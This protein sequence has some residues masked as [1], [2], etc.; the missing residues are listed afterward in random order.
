M[1]EYKNELE[2]IKGIL[3]ENPRGMTISE[4]A[5]KLNINRNAVAKYLDV[6]VISGQL[7]MESIGTAKVYYLSQR[8]P[9]STMLNF[10]SDYILVFDRSLKVIQVNDNFLDLSGLKKEDVIGLDVADS[11]LLVTSN[12]LIVSKMKAVVKGEEYKGE[13][14]IPIAQNL[15]YFKIKLIPSTFEDGNRGVTL[16]M[17][18]IT[19]EKE[20]EE[21]LKKHR[22]HL[23]EL[24][25][26]RTKEL[27][28][29]N[30]KLEEE[31]EVRRRVEE[32]L[33]DSEVKYSTLVEEGND[34]II[35]IQDYVVK[36]ANSVFAKT[37]GYTR[38]ETIG[39][40]LAE[41]I[42]AEHR[43]LVVGRYEKRIK[44][45]QTI[46]RKYE[47]DFLSKDGEK[48]PIEVN[49]SY[50]EYEDKP[51]DMAI[52]RDTTERRNL[53]R[54][55]DEFLSNVSHELKTPLISIIGYNELISDETLGPLTEQQKKA[56]DTVVRNS[57]RLRHVIDS[58]LY[59][60]LVRSGKIKY[61]FRSI[62]I[63]EVIENTIVGMIPLAKKNGLSIEAD[64]PEN[65]P[66]INGDMDYLK[67]ALT[68]LMDNAIKF[69]PSGGLIKIIATEDGDHIKIEVRDNGIGIPKEQIPDV[70]KLF[71]Q[72]DGSTTRSY[73]G[74]GLGM[75]VCKSIVEAH[76]G[77][78]WVE[79]EEGVGTTVR[80]L[81]AK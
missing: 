64:I 74:A 54:M 29:I 55:K 23:G 52:I 7:D 45:D 36:F 16:I 4:V 81:L 51:A 19:D 24:V 68:N 72:L 76:N 25:D 78:I 26:E 31:I 12:P 10:S 66:L 71:Y 46:P 50:I 47:V 37:L 41:F 38:E 21:A 49:T 2:H 34:G 8:I 40:P 42:S 14:S 18:N 39:K 5:D 32:E 44:N 75:Y 30:K 20:M 73:G 28:R 57:E 11:S 70:F 15:F 69:T 9:I 1:I 56:M 43:D 22:D 33:R 80:L 13:V 53:D 65:L 48:V 60:S 77:K 63:S 61:G 62:Q 3:K 59:L 79:S 58:L 67:Q 17:E 6:L 27:K 35:I